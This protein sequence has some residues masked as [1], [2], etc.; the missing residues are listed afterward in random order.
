IDPE[1]CNLDAGAVAKAMTSRTKAIIPVHLF[2]LVADMDAMMAVAEARGVAVVEDAAQSLGASYKGRQAGTLGTAGCFSFFPS[3]N[4]GGAGDG[5]LVTTQC[6]DRAAF[7]K[8]LRVHGALKK[9][10]YQMLGINSRLDAL[11]AAILRVKLP[12]LKRWTE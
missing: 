2:G 3:K 11:Q 7:L 6:G 5:G 8:A 1:T 10:E 12:H 9:Y 4:L